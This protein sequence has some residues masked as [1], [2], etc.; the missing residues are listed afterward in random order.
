MSIHN[1]Q[2]KPHFSKFQ[3]KL[4]KGLEH[5]KA[6]FSTYRAGRANPAVLDKILVD[7]WGTPTKIRDMANITVADARM[8]TIT[9]YDISAIKAI[10]KAIQDSDLGINPSDDGKMIRLGFPQLTEEKRKDLVK[11]IKK[12]AEDS[13]VVLRNERRDMVDVL[14]KLKK[15][16][17]LTEDE[18]ATYEKE[19]QKELDKMIE[20]VDKL[21]KDKEK[22]VLEI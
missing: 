8:L 4:S 6:E 19:V 22:E 5:L 13:K 15:D 16:S 11:N 10:N 17:L 14:K 2:V 20:S 9:P 7:Y 21:L 1:E 12:T 3:E 18:L